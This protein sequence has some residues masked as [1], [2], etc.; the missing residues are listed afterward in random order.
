MRL[1]VAAL[2]PHTLIAR[3]AKGSS[4]TKELPRKLWLWPQRGA[5]GRRGVDPNVKRQNK[6]LSIE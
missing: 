6:I 2:L 1:P 5:L 3:L 4:G